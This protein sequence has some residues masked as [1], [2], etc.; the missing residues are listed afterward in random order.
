MSDTPNDNS[1]F[2]PLDCPMC[3]YMMRDMSDCAQY[4]MSGCCVDCWIGFLEPL[5]K[6]KQDD[7]YLPSIAELE[8][9]RKKIRNFEMEKANS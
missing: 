4:Y 7:G 8:D 5:R 1:S 2:V 9:Y 6:Q 3:G